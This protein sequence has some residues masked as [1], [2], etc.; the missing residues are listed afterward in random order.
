MGGS[1]VTIGPRSIVSQAIEYRVVSQSVTVKVSFREGGQPGEEGCGGGEI[2][3]AVG[4][5][6]H[7]SASKERDGRYEHGES[8]WMRRSGNAVV[9]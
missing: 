4:D 8:S 9:S 3:V 6:A 1:W 7:V 5:D 2:V